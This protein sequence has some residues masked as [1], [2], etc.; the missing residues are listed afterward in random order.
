MS[1]TI[2]Q[3]RAVLVQLTQASRTPMSPG[4]HLTNPHLGNFLPHLVHDE[5]PEASLCFSGLMD[6]DCS[7]QMKS[8]RP[9]CFVIHQRDA[10]VVLHRNAAFGAEEVPHNEPLSGR[11][12]HRM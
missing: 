12:A 1:V 6:N 7:E 3:R 5:Q 11:E 2:T 9:S 4:L 10:F 8:L